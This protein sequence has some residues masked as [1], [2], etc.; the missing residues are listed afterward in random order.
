MDIL[1][2]SF[3][4]PYYLARCLYSIQEFVQGEYTVKILDDGTPQRY[5]DKIKSDFPWVE[6][7]KSREHA[8]KVA[9]IENHLKGEKEFSLSSI[10]VDLWV[11][12]VRNS[13]HHFLLL[14]EDAWFTQVIAL[15]EVKSFVEKRDIILLKLAWNNNQHLAQSRRIRKE[16]IFDEIAPAPA[17][18]NL[19]LVHWYFAN[20][21]KIRSVL[22]RL[23]IT[24]SKFRLSYYELYTVASAVFRKDYWLAV[25]DQ[26]PSSIQEGAQLWNALRW[27]NER[28]GGG[29][30]KTSH[31]VIHTSFST[32][33][34]NRFKMLDFDMLRLNNAL[35]EAWFV[36]RLQSDKG[37]PADFEVHDLEECLGDSLD[38]K[39]IVEWKKWIELFKQ[40]HR[41]S[42]S[43]LQ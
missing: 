40:I 1:I 7:E 23:G 35:N 29:Y 43:I 12:A 37:L 42:G 8:E 13:S 33:S 9:A 2:K 18:S 17:I 30:A 10:P 27:R 25:W 14:E 6:I 5:L 15:S 39:M 24:L 41:D 16:G 22:N 32:A 20:T 11:Q 38:R 26:A 21:C 31:E 36:G 4:R 28:K 3:Y 34:Y 19:Q